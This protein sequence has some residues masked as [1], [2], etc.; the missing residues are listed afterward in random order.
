VS[1]TNAG[2][3]TASEAGGTITVHGVA[4]GGAS[5]TAGFLGASTQKPIN[6]VAA[7]SL[8]VTVSPGFLG[9]YPGITAR[10]SAT[11]KDAAGNPVNAAVTWSSTNEK[12][13]TVD[14]TGLARALYGG[15]ASITATVAGG[16]GYGVLNVAHCYDCPS[17]P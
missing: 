9:A 8:V 3:I 4:Q 16:S 2:I 15:S 7:G 5:V 17:W 12:V 11:V 13:A 10:F 1:S 14:A 6:V